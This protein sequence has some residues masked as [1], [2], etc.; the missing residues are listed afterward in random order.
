[1]VCHIVVSLHFRDRCNSAFILVNWR[2]QCCEPASSVC[3]GPHSASLVPNAVVKIEAPAVACWLLLIDAHVHISDAPQW[4]QLAIRCDAGYR[5]A[6]T[7]SLFA[8]L[9]VF[10]G[11]FIK[12]TRTVVACY[13]LREYQRSRVKRVVS[14]VMRFTQSRLDIKIRQCILEIVVALTVRNCGPILKN[15][16][17]DD[18]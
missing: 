3:V 4:R 5:D 6:V 18:V 12:G 7:M 17:F 1:M 15:W 10:D 8:S 13:S 16:V 11:F 2:L 9:R 14:L